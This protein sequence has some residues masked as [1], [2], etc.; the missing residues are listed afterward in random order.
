MA[1]RSVN[2]DEIREFIPTACEEDS[3]P[4]IFGVSPTTGAES[5]Q[6]DADAINSRGF[7][8]KGRNQRDHWDGNKLE[9]LTVRQ[10]CSKVR[11][12]KSYYMPD[13]KK[14]GEYFLQKEIKTPE[15]IRYVAESLAPEVRDEVLDFSRE[16]WKLTDGE[17]KT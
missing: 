4:T 7:K 8:G 10:F 1:L 2:P 14:E 16:A 3:N 9:A 15:E 13:P 17:K 11:Y 5:S 12:V 6:W